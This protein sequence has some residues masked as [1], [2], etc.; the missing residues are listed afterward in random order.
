M[1]LAGRS[2]CTEQTFANII[3]RRTRETRRPDLSPHLFRNCAASSIA[4]DRGDASEARS[5]VAPRERFAAALPFLGLR[6]SA[7]L[8]C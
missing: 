3:R 5:A 7:T 2:P 6:V 8:C 1:D 4:V